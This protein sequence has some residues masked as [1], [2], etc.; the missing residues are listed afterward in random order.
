MSGKNK[1]SSFIAKGKKKIASKAP[2]SDNAAVPTLAA[3]GEKPIESTPAVTLDVVQTKV[4]EQ[5]GAGDEEEMVEETAEVLIHPRR[6]ADEEDDDE[7]V[8]L[9]SSQ[10]HGKYEWKRADDPLDE[11]A[12]EAAKAAEEA[13][14]AA[15]EEK[16][17]TAFGLLRKKRQE[18]LDMSQN[19]FPA[20]D[21][22]ANMPSA[23]SP[24]VAETKRR[25]AKSTSS[26]AQDTTEAGAVEKSKERELTGEDI[27]AVVGK[28]SAKSWP[29][30]TVD[31]SAV[32]NRFDSNL[33]TSVM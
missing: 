31:E 3:L 1:L 7:E 33:L 22:R 18:D 11:A 27:W 28:W 14:K 20:L 15:E 32:R 12:K 13:A 17:R 29:K 4:L 2:T 9:P 26:K 5:W 23:P 6:A 30:I 10:A 8:D 24:A 21:P 16:R 25:K 19:A